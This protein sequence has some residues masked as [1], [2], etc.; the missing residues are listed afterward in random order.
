MRRDKSIRRPVRRPPELPPA[1][2]ALIPPP[3]THALALVEARAASGEQLAEAI[4]IL[5]EQLGAGD[6][7]R[8]EDTML[9]YARLDYEAVLA[10][11]KRAAA[12]P[13]RIG[14][15]TM[16]LMPKSPAPAAPS[17]DPA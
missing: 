14:N 16:V 17:G 9:T 12:E 13:A 8:Y 10:E 4:R 6:L 7:G 2:G 15:G 5:T 3:K 1:T 11:K